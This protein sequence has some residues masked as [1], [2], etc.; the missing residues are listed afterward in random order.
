MENLT[1]KFPL[2]YP[3]HESVQYGNWFIIRYPSGE[4]DFYSKSEKR[5]ICYTCLP[6]KVNCMVCVPSDDDYFI[7]GLANG[8]II[9]GTIEETGV[10][11]MVACVKYYD[12][13]ITILKL[14]GDVLVSCGGGKNIYVHKVDDIR[15]VFQKIPFPKNRENIIK[16]NYVKNIKID[17]NEALIVYY[18]R[19]LSNS[20]WISNHYGSVKGIYDFTVKNNLDITTFYDIME[21]LDL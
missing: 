9:S 16:Y 7:F 12:T 8:F 6:G 13:K 1:I 10:F 17:E 14:L 3:A 19:G 21:E 4:I 18:K 20:Y 2:R 5:L 11:N 15:V